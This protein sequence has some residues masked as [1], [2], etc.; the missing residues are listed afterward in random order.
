MPEAGL[1][2]EI[3][4]SVEDYRV[5]SASEMGLVSRSRSDGMASIGPLITRFRTTPFMAC[6]PVRKTPAKDPFDCQPREP[7]LGYTETCVAHC[8]ARPW[9]PEKFETFKRQDENLENLIKWVRAYEVRKDEYG[10]ERHRAIYDSFQGNK[11][12]FNDPAEY[13]SV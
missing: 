13:Q 9:E 8:Q 10:L 5:D 4:E 6:Y 2:R 7:L 1:D 11:F 12:E 3:R